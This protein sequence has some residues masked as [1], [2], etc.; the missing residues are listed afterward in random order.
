MGRATAADKSCCRG[1][2]GVESLYIPHLIYCLGMNG[3]WSSVKGYVSQQIFYILGISK[4]IASSKHSSRGLKPFKVKYIILYIL[5]NC[6]KRA[7]YYFNF[8]Q[9]NMK[10]V[11]MLQLKITY[12]T[13]IYIDRFGRQS[14]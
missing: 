10:H 1:G 11:N 6:F 13:C 9:A 12:S 7:Q 4:Y 8:V 3:A 14:H 5:I 2:G